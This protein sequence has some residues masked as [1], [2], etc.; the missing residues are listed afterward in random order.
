MALNDILAKI[1]EVE[2]F[3]TERIEDGPP[4]TARGRAGRKAQ[5]I[6]SLKRFRRDY[7]TELLRTAAF[8]VVV[9]NQKDAFVN[10]AL[11]S[12]CY[13]ADPEEFYSSIVDRIPPSSYLG[14]E[15]VSNMFDIVGRHL[16]DKMIELEKVTGYPQLIFRQEYHRTVRSRDEFLSLV[17]SALVEQIGG[18]MVGIQAVHTITDEAIKNNHTSKFTPILLPSNDER[19]ALTVAKDLLTVAKDLDRISSRVF[20]VTA[21]EVRALVNPDLDV[22]PVPEVTES[23]VKK[24]LKTISN[25]LKNNK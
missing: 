3:A 15:S 5:S 18:E 25:K 10:A 1:K 7:A 12:R 21:G 20:V 16:E 2:P 11:E 8:I 22:V 9:G 14:R 23:N 6:E 13:K 17:K 24:A 4:E 19:F